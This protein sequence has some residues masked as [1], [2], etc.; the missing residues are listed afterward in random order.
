MTMDFLSDLFTGGAQA[1]VYVQLLVLLGTSTALILLM[2][3]LRLSPVLGYMAAGILIG[4]SA[5][6]LVRTTHT[7][8]QVAELGIAC[9]LFSIGLELSWARL[10]SMRRLVFG[11]GGLQV[12]LSTVC[13]APILWRL[14]LPPFAAALLALAFA[15]S[16]TAVVLQLLRER[17]EL[18]RR[19][20]RAAFAVLLFQDLAAVPLLAL[21]TM[22]ERSSATTAGLA[23]SVL[24]A[25]AALGGIVLLAKLL[26]RPLFQRISQ[27]RNNDLFV[28]FTL[29]V[30]IGMGVATQ[31]IGLSLTFGAF[32]AGLLLSGTEYRH[33]IEADIAPFKGLLLGLFFM[34]VG[35]RLDLRMA[36]YHWQFIAAA[37]VILTLL[38]GSIVFACAR[39]FGKRV[40]SALKISLWLAGAG[41]FAL[42]AIQA[43]QVSGLLT[44]EA[45]QLWLTIAVV[46]LALTPLLNALEKLR[47]GQAVLPAAEL[48]SLPAGAAAGPRVVI[49]GYGR[50]G[51][52]IAAQ[53]DGARISYL[54]IDQDTNR[55]AKAQMRDQPVYF[56]AA[57][58]LNLLH[59]LE[60]GQRQAFIVTLDRA[61]DATHAVE[62]VRRNWPELPILARAFDADH[63]LVLQ[64]AGANVTVTETTATSQ[65]LAEAAVVLAED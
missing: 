18:S 47:Y 26:S 5:L 11:F 62:C 39:A 2:Q 20:G 61:V 27:T 33:K 31:A 13:G 55:V 35:M 19:S 25:V 23:V 49:A 37:V 60:L 8:E 40:P 45:T 59:Q 43:M 6:Q 54:A 57:N 42:V 16:S 41:E 21:T 10:R 24:Q 51:E 64:Q 22:G 1:P 56:G 4:P 30:V 48:R 12:L 50:L 34:T 46:S 52:S 9:L 65:A 44:T 29:F 17:G 53:L 38:K 3:R 63:A 7:L 28:A 36:A 32:L 15:L 58:D 14:G